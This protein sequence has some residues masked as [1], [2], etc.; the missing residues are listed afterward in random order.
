M[1]N[2]V[3][4][5]P[6][7]IPAGTGQRSGQSGT[8]TAAHFPER[9]QTRNGHGAVDKRRRSERSR[10]RR[11]DASSCDCRE[12]LVSVCIRRG[13]AVLRDV[14]P[15]TSGAEGR[16]R[17]QVGLD[18]VAI[19]RGERHASHV[20]VQQPPVRT[21]S[22]SSAKLLRIRRTRARLLSLKRQ[23]RR[24]NREW[25]EPQQQQQQPRDNL[26]QLHRERALDHRGTLECQYNLLHRDS[27]NQKAV[28]MSK[29]ISGRC[30]LAITAA[31]TTS[32]T[33]TNT[34][35]NTTT[36]RN[37]TT[38]RDYRAGGES[39]KLRCPRRR[40]CCMRLLLSTDAFSS[41]SS[42]YYSCSRRLVL[43][44]RPRHVGL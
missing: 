42:S 21:T 6:Q 18:T 32:K 38:T 33:T 36:A 31:K 16:R 19:G 29:I 13:V 30:N 7:E 8:D 40:L 2:A 11:I 4:A 1:N 35:T 15:Q 37:T 24:R 26:P 34:T 43:L 41:S 9:L 3:R 39:K 25:A 22:S 10:R 20:Q 44:P 28:K 14:R 12:S 27:E 17:G 5:Q 23:R